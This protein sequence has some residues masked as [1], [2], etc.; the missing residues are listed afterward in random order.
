MYIHIIY[1]IV[2]PPDSDF[3]QNIITRPQLRLGL[4]LYSAWLYHPRPWG[5]SLTNSIILTSR[6]F[7]A[8]MHSCM[9][10][11]YACRETHADTCTCSYLH[12]LGRLACMVAGSPACTP[13]MHDATSCSKAC[14]GTLFFCM[15]ANK[16]ACIY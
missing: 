1:R 10:D 7:P 16:H 14:H 6:S 12:I 3:H 9:G 5:I 13:K 2:I 8:C 15:H 11:G 4:V